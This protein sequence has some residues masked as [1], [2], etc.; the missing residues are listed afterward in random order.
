MKH[1]SQQEQ[2]WNF[3]QH[4]FILLCKCKC[5]LQ[6]A[7]ENTSFFKKYIYIMNDLVN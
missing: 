3:G 4:I 2:L 1:N 6:Q 5:K 7:Q